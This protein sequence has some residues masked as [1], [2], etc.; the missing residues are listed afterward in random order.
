M[1]TA[2]AAFIAWLAR[3]VSGASAQGLSTLP[4]GSTIYFAN[5]SSHLDFIVIWSALPPDIRKRT[6]PV[7]AQDY[8]EASAARR[9][10]AA[11]VFNALLIDRSGDSLR[12]LREQM[13]LMSGALG[14]GGS[15]IIFPEGTRGDGEKLA[16]FQGG[17]YSLLRGAPDAVA[18]PVRLGNLNRILPKGEFLPVPQLSTVSFGNSIMIN[19]GERKEEFLTR[20][21][22]AILEMEPT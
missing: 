13:D 7:A 22:D 8:W 5:H 4:A 2:L 1:I 11:R 10:L 21:R 3:I 18:V 12:H 16:A 9:F 14:D 19:D 17:L 15:L 6:R 20:A